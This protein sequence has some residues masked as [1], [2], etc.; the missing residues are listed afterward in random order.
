MEVLVRVH[1]VEHHQ[2][3]WS[4]SP[5][6]IH[7]EVVLLVLEQTRQMVVREVN[8]ETE[9]VYIQEQDKV[10]FPLHVEVAVEQVL[11]VET[12]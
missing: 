12:V 7:L 10:I 1:I 2:T 9:V 11:Q 8:L 5:M 3:Q 4:V 6:V